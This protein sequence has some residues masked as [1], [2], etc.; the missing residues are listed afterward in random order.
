MEYIA[1]AEGKASRKLVPADEDIF[2]H[3]TDDRD[4]YQSVFFYTQEHY[5]QFKQT[6]S[7]AGITNVTTNR[8][9]WDFDDKANIEN[10][11]N[12]AK[13]LCQRLI[14]NNVPAKD[15]RIAFSGMKGYS[16]E[17]QTNQRFT[18]EQVKSINL[19][20]AGDLK[21][22]D[23]KIFDPQRI[24]RIVGTRHDVSGLYKFPLTLNQLMEVP[25]DE[26][27]NL[28]TDLNN[29]TESFDWERVALPPSILEIALKEPV[30]QP[31]PTLIDSPLD[32]DF[33]FKPKGFSNCKFA[34]MNGFFPGG[35]RNHMLMVLA[36]TCRA[37]GFPKEVAY[38]ICKAAARMQSQRFGSEPFAKEEIWNNIIE[39]VYGS[40]W[41][42]AQYSCKSDH[43][44]KSICSSLGP[45][46]CRHDKIEASLLQ[47]EEM[48]SQF[49]DYSE[50]IEANTI[51]TGL[52]GIDD[53][54]QLTI[55]MPVGLLG[56]PSSGKT[57]LSLN[58]LSNTSAMGISSCFF[59]MDMYG[60]LVFMKQIQKVSGLSPREIH[61]IFKHDK[62]R[63]GELKAKVKEEYK[64]V[65]FSLKSGHTVQDMRDIINEHQEQTGD[66]IKLVLIDYLECIAGPYSDATANTAKIA[67]ELKDFAI[68]MGVANIVLVQ[69]PKS[70][71]DASSP[72]T[73]MRQVK[74]SSMLEQSFR[75]IFGIYREG[76]GPHTTGDDK[77][78]TINT[79]KNTMGPLFS[80]DYYWN[81]KK[82]EIFDLDEDG[83]M[84][85]A[86]LRQRKKAAKEGD[87][88]W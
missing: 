41:K 74:G 58:M 25:S 52:K 77:F 64:N 36:A 55:G 81:G 67:G 22:N 65:K 71:G 1:I 59:S 32:L 29:V 39:V 23:T 69:P 38:N 84:E 68:E 61:E 85:L 30:M 60:P 83:E 72:L 42:G 6:R 53:N 28:A 73:S 48:G 18:P 9:V 76:F 15:I 33:K 19:S 16:V 7:L 47:V 14:T 45:N 46:K 78:I 31:L 66:K 3:I 24:I 11:R 49:E 80:Q 82:G 13:E 75:V 20:L 87:S 8:L 35:V 88:E 27:K 43:D 79:L 86:E 50:N 12:D 54:V 70:A 10:A 62:R 51:K 57:T 56:A 21:T 63:A 44:L 5:D 40:A 17:I 37:Q 34:V 2:S 26:I 4:Y